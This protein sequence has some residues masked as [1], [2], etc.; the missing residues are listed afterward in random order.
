MF[1]GQ[2]HRENG[3]P[4]IVCLNG[5]QE[6]WVHDQ[7]HR[8][9][10][11]AA[12]IHQ[13]GVREWWVHGG[14]H[15]DNDQP[16]IIDGYGNQYWYQYGRFGRSG[17]KPAITD[18]NGDTPQWYLEEQRRISKLSV[19]SDCEWYQHCEHHQEALPCKRIAFGLE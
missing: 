3:K 12:V 10:D 11:Q 2:R 18:A 17:K 13:D 5:D 6:W 14:R 15:R 16:A 9:D 7:R 4:A 19:A 8:S 1:H